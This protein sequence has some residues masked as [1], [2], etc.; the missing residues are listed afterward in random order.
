[1]KLRVFCLL[2][3]IGG[4][5]ISCSKKETASTTDKT[6]EINIDMESGFLNIEETKQKDNAYQ[7]QYY[8]SVDSV[9]IYG[10]GYL[11][12]IED[13]LK[14]YNLEVIVTAMLREENAPIEGSIA[15]SLNDHSGAV[16]NWQTLSVSQQNFKP[17]EW[18]KIEDTIK[19]DS[20]LLRE[21]SELKIFSM[22]QNGA[23]KLDVDN[24]NIKYRF[25]K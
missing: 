15:F 12:K 6:I 16:K 8:S 4:V 22:K 2:C 24:L 20:N 21:S 10:A 25:Y 11:K 13:T 3:A 1:M 17:R 18:C 5:L 7:G 9:R 19:Y 14:G 23:D